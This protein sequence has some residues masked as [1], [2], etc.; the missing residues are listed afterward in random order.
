LSAAAVLRQARAAGIAIV[1]DGED[2]VL[3]APA[4]PPASVIT[5]LG[6]HKSE[7][8]ALLRP[9]T[10]G[11]SADDWHAF[12]EKGAGVAAL[13]ARLPRE[14][15]EA[16]AFAC[17]VAEWLNRKLV[18]SPPGRCLGCGGSEHPHDKLLPFGAEQTGQA[19]LHSRC[20]HDW[21]A[22]RKAEAVATLSTFGIPT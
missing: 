8:L 19:W 13:E 14:E 9:G 18:Q 1:P 16:R 5:A 2:L 12:F 11:W 3:T 6:R 22:S 20:W 4:P 7:V 10:C 17:C 15:A 21:H